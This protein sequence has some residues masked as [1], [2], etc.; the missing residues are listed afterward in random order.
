MQKLEEV[1]VLML[2]DIQFLAGKEKTQE[3][4]HNI[5]NDFQS[6]NKQIVVTSD[7]APKSLIL[8]EARLQSRLTM[9]LVVDIKP[10]DTETR[11]AIL[12]TK[13]K[14]KGE[15]LDNE[16]LNLIAETIT[17]NVRELEGAINIILTK[18]KLLQTELSTEDIM[19]SL[20]TLGYEA[21]NPRTKADDLVTVSTPPPPQAVGLTSKRAQFDAIIDRLALQN[22]ISKHDLLGSSRKAAVSSA[23]QMAMYIAKKDFGWTL[24]RI[25]NYF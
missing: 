16:V 8:L 3:I 25:G 12:E 1:D 17:S 23:R 9:G 19:E 14:T 7:L 21:N 4:F 22:D 6:K 11:I 2:D 10:P 18:K 13:L 5:F 24:E 20:A 15:K